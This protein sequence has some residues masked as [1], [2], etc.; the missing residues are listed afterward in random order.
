MHYSG[1]RDGKPYWLTPA[2]LPKKLDDEFHFDFDPCP[3]PVPPLFDDLT[4][5]WEKSNY[6]NPPFVRSTKWVRKAIREHIKN[7]K[8]VFVSRSTD[9][10]IK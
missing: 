1:T 10:F 5:E 3:Y 4:V 8:V 2:D 9:R 6:V 7:R